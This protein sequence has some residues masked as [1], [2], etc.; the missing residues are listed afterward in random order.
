MASFKLK[1]RSVSKPTINPFSSGLVTKPAI[2]RCNYDSLIM[3]FHE[4]DR[5]IPLI[6]RDLKIRFVLIYIEAV[7]IGFMY[8]HAYNS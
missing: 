1:R 4:E 6:N 3:V 7:K 8:D 5:D 2:T